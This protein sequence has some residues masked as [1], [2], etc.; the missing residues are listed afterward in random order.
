MAFPETG[1]GIFP[2]LGGMLRFSRHAGPEL[3]KYYTFTGAGLSAADAA[4]LGVVTKLVEPAQVDAAIADLAAAGRP[5]KYRARR[6]PERFE[7]LAALCSRENA[8]RLLSG[9]KPEGV[10]EKR[11]EKT[12]K[13]VGY[14][15]PLALKLADEIIDAQQGKPMAEAVEIELGRLSE[16]F[17]SED[18]LEGLSS[19][20]RKRPEFKGK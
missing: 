14:K 10:D 16:I 7:Q 8:D 3:A 19:M 5:D 4:D 20:G 12:L 11:A 6:I 9:Q 1:I 2:G 17:S 18:A 15:A 13:I